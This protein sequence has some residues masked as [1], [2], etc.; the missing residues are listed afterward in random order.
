MLVTSFLAALIPIA[1]SAA[2]L[3]DPIFYPSESAQLVNCSSGPTKLSCSMRYEKL[4]VEIKGD[5]LDIESQSI[6][7]ALKSDN[8]QKTFGPVRNRQSFSRSASTYDWIYAL[9]PWEHDG[10]PFYKFEVWDA[11]LGKQGITEKVIAKLKDDGAVLIA[12]KINKEENDS[13]L[14]GLTKISESDLANQA[15]F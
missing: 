1:M 8:C 14:K 6:V 5:N 13:R 2:S 10:N 15:A 12:F 3:G 11:V 9:F 4:I 7:V